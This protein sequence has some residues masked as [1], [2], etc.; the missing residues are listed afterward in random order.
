METT[1]ERLLTVKELAEILAVPESWIYGHTAVG[2]IPTVR[3]GRYVRFRLGDVLQW[4]RR[5]GE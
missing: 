5:D 1:I 4:L 3:V 2:D